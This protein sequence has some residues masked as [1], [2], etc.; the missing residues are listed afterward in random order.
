MRVPFSPYHVREF[1]SMVGRRFSAPPPRPEPMDCDLQLRNGEAEW[2]MGFVGDICPL[3]GREAHVGADVQAFLADCDVIVGNFEGVFSDRLWQPFL[4]KHDP[5]IFGVLE[6][7]APLEHWVVSVANNHATDF[8]MGAL[9]RTL[10]MLDRRGL[11]W[12]GTVERP[13]LVLAGDV[14]LTAWTWWLNRPADGVAREDPGAPSRS[15]LHIALPHWG[16]EHE[17]RP[18]SSQTV[19][20]GYDLIVGHHTHLPQP[21]EQTSDDRLVAWSIGNFV[22]GKQLPV[23]GEGALLKVGIA[24]PEEKKPEIVRTQFREIDLDRDQHH[25][26]VSF[27]QSTKTSGTE[28]EKTPSESAPASGA[29]SL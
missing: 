2:T 9:R 21:F 28:E 16:Y 7:I 25:C 26:R 1:L 22:T 5:S 10:D 27:R 3:F 18:R 23:L 8:G 20:P 17:R 29:S 4:M 6:Q 12:L 24:R 14:T 13:R 11:R 15:G 19:P